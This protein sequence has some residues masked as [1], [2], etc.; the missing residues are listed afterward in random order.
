ML[1]VQLHYDGY[2]GHCCV[3]RHVE[4]ACGSKRRDLYSPFEKQ[5]C[6]SRNTS[7]LREH[8]ASRAKSLDNVIW[9]RVRY[10]LTELTASMG[11]SIQ[12]FSPLYRRYPLSFK[13]FLEHVNEKHELSTI[14]P[15][16]DTHHTLVLMNLLPQLCFVLAT[17]PAFLLYFRG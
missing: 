15:G 4:G 7:F 10:K 16:L 6:E 2:S 1:A 13:L 11:P 14:S 3:F 5:T 12:R 9:N 17:F 8:H